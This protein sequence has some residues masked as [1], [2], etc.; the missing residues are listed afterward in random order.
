MN[1]TVGE[2]VQKVQHPKLKQGIRSAINDFLYTRPLNVL[3][4][5][6]DAVI[7]KNME[8]E[9]TSSIAVRFKGNCYVLSGAALGRLVVVPRLHFS[10]DAEMSAILKEKEEIESEQALAM[11]SLTVILNASNCVSDYFLLLP[12][13]LH[14]SFAVFDRAGGESANL[15]PSS[16]NEI[17]QKTSAGVDAMRRRMVF[18]LLL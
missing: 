17:K 6:L 5:R 4:D 12:N 15:S 7:I 10:L 8:L 1:T 13:S 14:D 9:N 3:S 2:Y 11:T 18:N 16:I